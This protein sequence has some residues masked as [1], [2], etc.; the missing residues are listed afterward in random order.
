MTIYY[1]LSKKGGT[2]WFLAIK[3][4]FEISHMLLVV[5]SQNM[6]MG[7][8][9]RLNKSCESQDLVDVGRFNQAFN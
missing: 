7:C 3:V 2:N 1:F 4:I 8:V 9:F 6:T 5:L